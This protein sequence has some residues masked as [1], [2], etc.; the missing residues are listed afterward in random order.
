MDGWTADLTALVIQTL[1]LLVGQMIRNEGVT[2][3]GF[4]TSTGLGMRRFIPTML[5]TAAAHQIAEAH[6]LDIN[7]DRI[8]STRV[9]CTLLKMR[10]PKERQQRGGKRGWMVAL[11]DVIRW[12]ESYGLDPNQITGLDVSPHPQPGTSGKPGTSDT[13][14]KLGT[15]PRLASGTTSSRP[16]RFGRGCPVRVTT[17]RRD[18]PSSRCSHR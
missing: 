7:L 9:G 6:E 11:E 18:P 13:I 14:A 3:T 10:L 12:G 5:V 1:G 8:T 4:A 2:S 16:Q 17:T 15:P